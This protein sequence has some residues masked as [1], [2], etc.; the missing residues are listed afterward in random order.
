MW[1]NQYR[2]GE[3][4]WLILNF[5]CCSLCCVLRQ[6][7]NSASFPPCMCCV[8]TGLVRCDQ[9]NDD[10]VVQLNQKYPKVFLSTVST[11]MHRVFNQVSDLLEPSPP[12]NQADVD[13]KWKV[14]KVRAYSYWNYN[15]IRREAGLNVDLAHLFAHGLHSN[16]TSK[17]IR[18]QDQYRHHCSPLIHVLFSFSLQSPFPTWNFEG[19]KI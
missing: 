3:S 9:V 11:E 19:K 1:A 16:I 14:I 13:H 15:Q 4:K 17:A 7:V 8:I 12:G 18:V 2:S 10:T 5:G 6:R